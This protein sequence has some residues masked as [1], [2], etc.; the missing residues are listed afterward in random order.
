MK[1]KK[2]SSNSRYCLLITDIIRVSRPDDISKERVAEQQPPGEQLLQLAVNT[3]IHRHL[4]ITDINMAGVSN[5]GEY[6]IP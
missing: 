1:E 2:N 5:E 6:Q 4:K 3:Y